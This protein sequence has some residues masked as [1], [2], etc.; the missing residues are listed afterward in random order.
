MH[1]NTWQYHTIY[2]PHFF[3]S[4]IVITNPVKGRNICTYIYYILTHIL[5]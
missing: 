1:L 4:V 5:L 3:C 2:P